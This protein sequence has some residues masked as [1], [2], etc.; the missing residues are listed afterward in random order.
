MLQVHTD[1]IRGGLALLLMLLSLA[2][3][4][5]AR[6]GHDAE[7]PDPVFGGDLATLRAQMPL[8]EYWA[9]R[10]GSIQLAQR[11]PATTSFRPAQAPTAV[12][13]TKESI[14]LH[15]EIICS[16]IDGAVPE[17]QLAGR[18]IPALVDA[19]GAPGE[20]LLLQ[21]DRELTT[22][23]LI[24]VLTS[25]AAAGVSR[26][27]L[28]G[29]RVDGSSQAVVSTSIPLLAEYLGTSGAE[30]YLV[31]LN[32]AV[33]LDDTGYGLAGNASVLAPETGVVRL[34]LEGTEYPYAAL[35][36]LLSRVKEEYPDEDQVSL[37]LDAEVPYH[38]VVSTLDACR[39]GAGGAEYLFPAPVIAVGVGQGSGGLAT[40]GYGYGGGGFGPKVVDSGASGGSPIILGALDKSSIETEIREHLA[41]IRYCYQRPLTLQ[42]N[43]S[44]KVVYKFV[45]SADGTVSSVEVKETTLAQAA[46]E[47]CV[48]EVIQKMEFPPPRGG[49]IVIVSY[50]FIFRPADSGGD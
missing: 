50:P 21:I 3:A 25:G 6:S 12:V 27:E 17:D 18:C 9:F 38:V 30:P 22:E 24:Q 45:I 48:S 41:Q 47:S 34:P 11:L 44:G 32:L 15:G 7:G 1:P 20:S 33:V 49:G 46:V 10:A 37:V 5:P 39:G 16:L 29:L 2:A 36:E 26:F 35:T 23:L 40:F 31:P 4:W 43:L 8:V 19:L 13:V 14:A 42:P 28:A